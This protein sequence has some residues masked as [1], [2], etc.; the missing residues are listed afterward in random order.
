[1]KVKYFDQF[2]FNPLRTTPRHTFCILPINEVDHAG[3]FLDIMKVVE[4]LD[5]RMGQ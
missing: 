5:A 4:V 2:V 3:H 1:M